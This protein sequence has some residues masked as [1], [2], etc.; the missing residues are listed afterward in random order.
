MS[1]ETTAERTAEQLKNS[2][3]Q[4]MHEMADVASDTA[5]KVSSNVRDWFGRQAQTAKDAASTVRD[6]ATAL[7]NR[8]QQYAREE[9]AKTAFILLATAAVITGI[10]WLGMRRR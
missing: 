3:S 7:S 8:T 1:Y 5:S 4:T 2:A 9:P 10:V 6:E